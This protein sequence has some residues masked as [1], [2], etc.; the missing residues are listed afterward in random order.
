MAK[1]VHPRDPLATESPANN[2]PNLFNQC[3]TVSWLISMPRSNSS[4]STFR[5]E[6]GKRTYIITTNRITSGD[7]L[8]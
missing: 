7:D 6:R 3:R 4:S 5:K 2:G 8:K 1:A